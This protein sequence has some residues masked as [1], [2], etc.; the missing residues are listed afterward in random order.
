M[1]RKKFHFHLLVTNKNWF[2]DNVLQVLSQFASVHKVNANREFLVRNIHKYNGILLGLENIIDYQIIERSKNLKFIATPTTG[3]SHIDL[4]IAKKKEVTI[5][6]LKNEKKFLKKISSTAELTW[7]LILSCA[8]NIPQARSDVI[9]GNWNREN[10]I[11]NE[12]FGKTLGII[13]YGRLGTKVARFGR[14]FGMK[15]IANDIQ[16]KNLKCVQFLSLKKVLRTSDIVSIHLPLNNSTKNLIDYEKISLLK[17]NA[18]FINTSRGE[19]IDEEAL[20]EL[21]IKKKISSAALDV[22][23]DENKLKDNWTKNNSLIKY[24]KKNNNLLIVPHIG[25]AS[26]ESIKKSNQFI[27]QKIIKYLK[28]HI[29]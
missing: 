2:S 23:S 27:V 26:V 10:Y 24:A 14:A 19:I 25:G 29:L 21:L 11:G 5:I 7:A 16:K 20:L 3:L 28:L 6:S 15:V 1:N 4:E 13:G 22:L 17:K 12:L 9:D 18:I 8:R